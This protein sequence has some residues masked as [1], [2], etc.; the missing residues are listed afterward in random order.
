MLTVF[1][2]NKKKTIFSEPK[3]L[4]ILNYT[5]AKQIVPNMMDLGI[6]IMAIVIN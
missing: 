3:P 4:I 5:S 2:K 1:Y 6:T